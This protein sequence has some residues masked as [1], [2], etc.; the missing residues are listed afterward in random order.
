MK[1]VEVTVSKDGSVS[2]EAFGFKGGTC[3]EA[4]AFLDKIL[5]SKS[6]RKY[7][8]SYYEQAETVINSLP[9]GYCG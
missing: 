5:G 9:N 8:S 2:I 1:K 6:D 3:E 4:T 7:K